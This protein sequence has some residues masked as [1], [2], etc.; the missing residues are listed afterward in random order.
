MDLPL[1][2]V[3]QLPSHL[4][5]PVSPMLQAQPQEEEEGYDLIVPLVSITHS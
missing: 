2:V 4:V 5:Q 1:L 3:I